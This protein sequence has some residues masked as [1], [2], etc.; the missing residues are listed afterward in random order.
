MS[1]ITKTRTRK[2][3]SPFWGFS[4]YQWGTKFPAATCNAMACQDGRMAIYL[5][6]NMLWSWRTF[7]EPD[8]SALSVVARQLGQ[9]I[10]VPG[11][12]AR[13]AEERYRRL[14]GEAL[15]TIE[16][17]LPELSRSTSRATRVL[18]QASATRQ[19]R[20]GQRQVVDFTHGRH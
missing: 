10:Y 2:R 5:D 15:D 11:I 17:A 1:P 20:T 6:A 12:A 19:P 13:E 8:R 18:A 16:S 9:E 7:T 3:L 14:L 4:R